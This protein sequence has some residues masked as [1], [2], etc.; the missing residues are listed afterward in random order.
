MDPIT[1]GTYSTNNTTSASA[2]KSSNTRST[3][4]DLTIDDFFTLLAAQ[5]QN[6][7]VMD[8][9][10][11]TEFIGQ[12]A[13]FATL[14]Q[15]SELNSTAQNT[16]AVSLIGKTVTATAT[17]STTG[18]QTSAEGSVSEVSIKNGEVYLSIDGKSFGIGDIT[19]ISN[20]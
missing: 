6:Q 10:D 13:Q 19:Q 1:Y 14:T 18:K 11:N 12:M 16:F 7:N 20:S 5:L 15:V 9:A 17:D 2:N 3:G 8:P 4:S